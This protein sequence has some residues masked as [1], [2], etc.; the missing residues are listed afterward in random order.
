MVARLRGKLAEVAGARLFLV[1]VSDLRTGGRQSNA[2]YQ[3]TLLSDDTATLYQ[4]APRLTEALQKS[5][6]LKDVNSDQQQGGLETDLTIDRPTAMRLGLTLSAIDNTLYDAFGQ[7]QVST[8]YNAL[9]QY[10]VVME[11][12]PRYWQD[13]STLRDIWVSTSG[14]NPTGSQQSNAGAGLF[15]SVVG[16]QF[17]VGDRGRFRAQSGDEFSRRQ[18]PFQRLRRGGGLHVAG[19]HDSACP[20]SRISSPAGRR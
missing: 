20:R 5:D 11:V 17:G 6:I 13:P 1:A 3:Y 10:H 15:A 12:A 8:I 18:R 19:D 4:W 2:T 16:D 7:R 9:N 14:A